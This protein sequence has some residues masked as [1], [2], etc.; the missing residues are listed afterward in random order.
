MPA[1]SSRH[2]FSAQRTLETLSLRNRQRPT[3]IASTLP[4]VME[5]SNRLIQ[6]KQTVTVISAALLGGL[7]Q[8]HAT[9]RVI[10]ISGKL[11]SSTVTITVIPTIANATNLRN[12]PREHRRHQIVPAMLPTPT[13]NA[14]LGAVFTSGIVKTA[15]AVLFLP[16]LIFILQPDVRHMRQ[17]RVTAI[18]ACAAR[19]ITIVQ[20]R[21]TAIG[22]I[23]CAIAMT[24]THL[25]VLAAAVIR[26]TPPARPMSV[27]L[28]TAIP[29]VKYVCRH[30]LPPRA[31]AVE[32]VVITIG[33]PV[34]QILANVLPNLKPGAPYIADVNLLTGV[35]S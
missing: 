5:G 31:G 30:Q 29:F 27:V 32:E 24:I 23:T 11:N 15:E 35:P 33:R 18:A 17:N 20:I 3:V 13:A 8:P 16:I 34:A 25:D 10:A 7:S 26:L 6:T 14:S 9:S 22:M 28:E 21:L 12:A 4:A 2:L 1:F 19:T